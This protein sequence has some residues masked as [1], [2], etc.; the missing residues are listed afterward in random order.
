MPA[1]LQVILKLLAAALKAVG[2]KKGP[3]VKPLP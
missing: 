1:A 3:D 2:V